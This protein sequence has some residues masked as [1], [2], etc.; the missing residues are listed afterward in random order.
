MALTVPLVAGE[1][2][3]LQYILG[4]SSVNTSFTP[5]S[6]NG[7]VLHLYSN[8]PSIGNSTIISQLTECTSAGYAPITLVS[9]SWTTTQLSGVT[10][11]VYSAQT[12]NFTTNAVA[13]GY[14]VTDCTSANTGRGNL[15]WL[16][17]FTGAPFSI[18]DNGG[19]IQI[20]SKITLA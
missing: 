20:S 16:E 18:P 19:N 11:G 7:P 9:T 3:M 2:L 8:D 17:R 13:Y 1:Y 12:F 15:L 14:Y 4:L 5:S 10:T 6:S